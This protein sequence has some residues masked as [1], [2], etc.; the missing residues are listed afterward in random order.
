MSLKIA[1]IKNRSN[2]KMACPHC[3]VLHTFFTVVPHECM[4]CK[5]SFSSFI[6]TEYTSRDNKGEISVTNLFEFQSIRIKWA[7]K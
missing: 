3:E 5:K 2:F 4:K 7:L 6:G 1:F